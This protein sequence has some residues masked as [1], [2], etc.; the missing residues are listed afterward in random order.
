[1]T[2]AQGGAGGVGTSSST[3][4]L[5]PVRW[6]CWSAITLLQTL[7]LLPV[8]PKQLPRF[9]DYPFR[10]E[11]KIALQLLKGRRRPE[12]RHA[13][14]LA[15]GADVTF[16]TQSRSLLHREARGN[17]GRQY[18]VTVRLRLELEDVPRGHGNNAGANPL[19]QQLL[20]RIDRESDLAAGGDQDDL[21]FSA[22]RVRHDVSATGHA[23]G[24][25]V[26]A[27]VER[28]QR[29]TRQHDCR[30]LVPKLHDHAISLG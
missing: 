4:L 22:R 12:G 11:A 15:G 6:S 13:D 14:D 30:R 20:M 17:M 23:S 26:L 3:A 18:T 19:A 8:V 1:M 16:P 29:L 24:G 27:A 25:R 9:G 10:L 2:I 5:V 7:P 21:R 28:R